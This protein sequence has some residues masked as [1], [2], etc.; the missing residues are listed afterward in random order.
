MIHPTNY[1]WSEQLQE[2]TNVAL[3]E[4]HLGI[5]DCQCPP[6]YHVQVFDDFTPPFELNT[7]ETHLLLVR[8]APYQKLE[9]E[10]FLAVGI[11]PLIHFEA[12][13]SRLLVDFISNFEV[14]FCPMDPQSFHK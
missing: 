9:Q 12:N 8:R 11:Y 14:F 1:D 6:N 7:A 13:M 5:V 4:A 3:L 2:L 10:F